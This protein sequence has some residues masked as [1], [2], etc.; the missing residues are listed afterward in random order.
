MA[1]RFLI[2]VNLPRLLS[3]WSGDEFAYVQDI[4]RRWT[5]ARI[6]RFAETEGLTIIT[7]DSDFSHRALTTISGPAVVHL[8]VGNMVFDELDAFVADVWPEVL[9][10]LQD[11]KLVRVYRDRVEVIG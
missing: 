10:A 4:D 5:D 1:P 9:A 8:R 3:A 7:K 6:W 11:S 2:D